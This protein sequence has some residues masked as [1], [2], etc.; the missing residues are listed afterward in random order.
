MKPQRT[1]RN[2]ICTP[3]EITFK[4]KSKVVGDHRIDFMI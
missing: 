2:T 4:Y 1:Q 3:K